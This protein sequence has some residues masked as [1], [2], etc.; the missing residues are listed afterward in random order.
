MGWLSNPFRRPPQIPPPG[1]WPPSDSPEDWQPG[2]L[3]ECIHAGPWYP[4]GIYRAPQLGEV[5]RV[6]SVSPG[7]PQFLG[8][9][10]Y[11]PFAFEAAGFR[12]VRPTAESQFRN[13]VVIIGLDLATP[14]PAPVPQRETEDA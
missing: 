14:Q 8:F 11:L 1:D 12:K 9:K 2:D 5:R 10:R 3:A 4:Q 7:R 6:E 13:D